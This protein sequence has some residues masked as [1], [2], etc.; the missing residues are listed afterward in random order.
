[1]RVSSS[2]A[3]EGACSQRHENRSLVGDECIPVIIDES[4]FDTSVFDDEEDREM[5]DWYR[6]DIG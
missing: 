6:A 5:Y 4:T 1:L 2:N 3:G